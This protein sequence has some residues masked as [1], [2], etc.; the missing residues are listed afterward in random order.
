[1]ANWNIKNFLRLVNG[2]DVQQVGSPLGAGMVALELD[3]MVARGFGR[4]VTVGAFSTPVAG[5]GAAAIIDLDQPRVAVGVPPGFTIRPIRVD[6]QVQTGLVAADNDE[7]EALI[8]VDVYGVWQG[9]G[10]STAE[11]PQNLRTDLKGGSACRVGS[12]FTADMTTIRT[13]NTGADPVLDLELARTVQTV[14]IILATAGTGTLMKE[15]RL[16]YEPQFAPFI[17]GPATL[18]VYYGGTVANVGGFA[19]VAWVEG[20]NEDFFVRP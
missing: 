18:L 10:T 7:N 1:M 20:R 6:V 15:L 16:L 19:Q 17:V 14:D 2:G 5:G 9:D 11:V 12:T 8:A 3:Q 13:D 4:M